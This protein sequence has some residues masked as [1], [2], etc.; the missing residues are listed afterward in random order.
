MISNKIAQQLN[1]RNGGIKVESEFEKG[2]TFS[3]KIIDY[4]IEEKECLMTAS[5]HMIK[6]IF[7]IECRFINKPLPTLENDSVNLSFHHKNSIP[8]IN[9][10]LEKKNK[11]KFSASLDNNSSNSKGSKILMLGSSLENNVKTISSKYLSRSHFFF[12]EAGT[13]KN[14][15][16]PEDF[17]SKELFIEKKKEFIIQQMHLRCTC[18]YILAV[19]DNDFNNLTMKIHAKRLEI[20]IIT[21][22]S[23]NEA[24][25]KIQEQENNPCCDHFKLI[26]MDIEMPIMDGLQAYQIIKKSYKEKKRKLYVIGVTGHAEGSE[27]MDEVK[28]IMEDV[29][30]KPISFE[31]LVMFL[32][33][34]IKEIINS[35]NQT[36]IARERLDAIQ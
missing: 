14:F 26:F 32:E 28:K 22:L 2:S 36:I 30:V 17:K 25:L 29:L 34:Q 21:A 1:E 20:P 8:S 23:A 15:N 6:N 9:D 16:S 35:E 31:T 11:R 5:D 18:P 7:K 4:L 33:K 13:F 24:L 19:D 10:I 3:F 27:R 12:A